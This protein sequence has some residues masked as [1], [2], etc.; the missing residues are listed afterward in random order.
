MCCADN[1]NC[2]EPKVVLT[3]KTLISYIKVI[4]IG[5]VVH[6]YSSFKWN[7]SNTFPI[8]AKMSIVLAYYSWLIFQI[9]RVKSWQHAPLLLPIPIKS[10]RYYAWIKMTKYIDQ[11]SFQLSGME[12]HSRDKPSYFYNLSLRQAG[13]AYWFLIIKPSIILPCLSHLIS[14]CPF[15]STS[16][17]VHTTCVFLFVVD[18]LG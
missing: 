5:Y 2:K 12:W 3:I 6:T 17:L 18:L 10:F 15:L 16:H 13:S 8:W 1:R 4:M 7:Y 11:F 9:N 14:R